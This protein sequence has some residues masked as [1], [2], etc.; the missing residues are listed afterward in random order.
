MF[1]V[2]YGFLSVIN[3][4]NFIRSIRINSGVI[5]KKNIWFSITNKIQKTHGI[6]AFLLFFVEFLSKII[7]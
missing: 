4:T 3:Q 5:Y 1:Y 6:R 7:R 2:L